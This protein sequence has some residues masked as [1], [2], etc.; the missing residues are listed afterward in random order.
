MVEEHEAYA[1]EAKKAK[2]A[3][4]WNGVPPR[5]I[6]QPGAGEK[7]PGMFPASS[8]SPGAPLD[9]RRVVQEGSLVVGVSD[10]SDRVLARGMV[11][12]GRLRFEEA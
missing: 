4:S 1:K 5:C 10:V 9:T 7:S 6:G 2:K 11:G 8:T 12:A 3:R